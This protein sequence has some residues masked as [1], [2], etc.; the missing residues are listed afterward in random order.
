MNIKNIYYFHKPII[1]RFI[2]IFFRRIAIYFKKKK[3]IINEV[4]PIDRRTN[5]IPDGFNGWPDKKL[6]AFVLRHDIETEKGY[7]KYLKL[8]ELDKKIG[9]KSSFNF[10]PKKYDVANETIELIAKN[11]FEL[12]V[13]G[14][15]HD[16]KLYLSKKR[17]QQRAHVINHY[18]KLWKSIGFYSPSSHHKLD[19][20]QA[21]DIEYD[22][23]TFDTDPFEPQSDSAGTIY[24]FF[25]KD[26]IT[27]NVYVEIP[28]TLPQDFT[29]FILMKQNNIDIWKSKMDWIAKNG[30][31]VFLNTHPDYMCFNNKNN[32]REYP[33][34][35]YIE[36]L[37]YVKTE[38]K[39]QYWHA[40]PRQVARYWKQIFN[41]S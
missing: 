18:L 39:G 24:P 1:P 22:S 14:L 2:Q 15:Y 21:L 36:F 17:F 32:G 9:Y 6:F 10:V 7:N 27:N 8:L 12:G 4:W 16:G 35:R 25:V 40:L 37:E 34:S 38:Y 30:G 41:I 23:S 20:L 5:T 28:Y 26:D 11:G 33:V 19:W 3:Y 31:L 13:H 29:L